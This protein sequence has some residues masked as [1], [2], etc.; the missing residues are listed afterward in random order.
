L[1]EK[2]ASGGVAH[3]NWG[4]LLSMVGILPGNKVPPMEIL[5]M[6]SCKI[7][8]H[9]LH[10]CAICKKELKAQSKFNFIKVVKKNA[11]KTFI[12]T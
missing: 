10:F 6:L 5:A 2:L 1:F 12:R 11:A 7:D 9:S 3:W 4:R 8:Q